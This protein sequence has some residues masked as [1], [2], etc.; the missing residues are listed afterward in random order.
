MYI[1]FFF[2]SSRRRHTR[3]QGD[4]SSDVCSS[5]LERCGPI[6][7]LHAPLL[8]EGRLAKQSIRQ[9]AD[10]QPCAAHDDWLAAPPA[11][12]RST[13]F[14]NPARGIARE[15]SRAV[16]LP[17]GYE[18]QASMRDARPRLT[19]R[20]GGTD[21]EAAIDLAGVCRDHRDRGEGREAHGD[22]CLADAS[23]AYENRCQV[24][25]VRSDQTDVPVPL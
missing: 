17:G 12:S 3:L 10:V 23:G 14:R 21:V 7:Q 4:W 22:G 5:D 19:I 13:C 6:A 20:F 8:I 25:G 15:P 11:P 2:F 1:N 16:T 24:S 18:I 9:R